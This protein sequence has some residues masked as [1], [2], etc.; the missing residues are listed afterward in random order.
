MRF[1]PMLRI[2]PLPTSHPVWEMRFTVTLAYARNSSTTNVSSSVWDENNQWN[3]CLF[4]MF[5]PQSISNST[6]L[7]VHN[8]VPPVVICFCQIGFYS[9]LFFGL[10]LKYSLLCCIHLWLREH[11][12]IMLKR[13]YL[14]AVIY[15]SHNHFTTQIITVGCTWFYDGLRMSI[16]DPTV[17]PTLDCVGSINNPS[18]M[19]H[20]LCKSAAEEN[21]HV[22]LYIQVVF[23]F[24]VVKKKR[25]THTCHTMVMALTTKL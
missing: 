19:H 3:H 1:W 5:M 11:L 9:G 16:T 14:A 24:T 6:H 7:Q 10:I 23:K 12:K 25:G 8:T 2:F 4:A 20:S 17:E 21:H 13:Y 15:Y 22:R 18:F